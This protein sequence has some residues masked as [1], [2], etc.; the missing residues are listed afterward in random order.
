MLPH[1]DLAIATRVAT[2]GLKRKDRFEMAGSCG[3][4]EVGGASARLQDRARRVLGT[5]RIKPIVPGPLGLRVDYPDPSQT[6]NRGCRYRSKPLNCRDARCR[7]KISIE[8]APPPLPITRPVLHVRPAPQSFKQ[9]R[10][11]CGRSTNQGQA[12]LHPH[13]HQLL[14]SPPLIF[15]RR[16]WQ[17]LSTANSSIRRLISA[18]H[19][20]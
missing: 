14:V 3:E 10:S 17:R 19:L 13:V 9:A 11:G 8:H 1:C 15:D 18:L 2:H 16:P 5:K 6:S 20:V 7:L 12:S 4:P